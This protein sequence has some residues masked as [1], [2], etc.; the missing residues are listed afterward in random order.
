MLLID[1]IF[2]QVLKSRSL[3]CKSTNSLESFS[4]KVEEQP[5][6][7]KNFL[8]SISTSGICL[9]IQLQDLYDY[10]DVTLNDFKV[11]LSP[12]VVLVLVFYICYSS[13]LSC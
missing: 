8:N 4:S 1:D 10:F 11:R 13:F 3:C 9:G 7:L 6:S 5:Y 12:Y 2:A